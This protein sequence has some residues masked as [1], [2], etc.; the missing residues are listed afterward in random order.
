MAAVIRLRR[1]GANDRPYYKV[2]VADKRKRRDGRFIEEVGRYNPMQ[3]GGNV[4]LDL[5]KVEDWLRKGAQPSETV[6]SLIKKERQKKKA[7]EEAAEAPS[8]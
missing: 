1:E 6:A 2:V 8:P 7:G 4:T 3:D 5:E